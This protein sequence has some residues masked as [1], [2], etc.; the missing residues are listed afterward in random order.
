MKIL[1][2]FIVFISLVQF[3]ENAKILAVFPL[4]GSSH[5]IMFERVLKGLAQKGHEVD[6]VSHFPLKQPLPG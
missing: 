2:F 1:G 3:I 4:P 6:V 5:F